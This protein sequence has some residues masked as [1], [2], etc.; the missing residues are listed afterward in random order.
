MIKVDLNAS[1]Y[2]YGWLGRMDYNNK[3][4]FITNKNGDFL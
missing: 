4:K 3:I 2:I 1:Q